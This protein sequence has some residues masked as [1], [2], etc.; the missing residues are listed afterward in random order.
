M[1]YDD[2][3]KLLKRPYDNQLTKEQADAVKALTDR[4]EYLQ[5]KFK[6]REKPKLQTMVCLNG[7]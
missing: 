3:V 7:L 1:R 5:S 4:V 6:T 2:A